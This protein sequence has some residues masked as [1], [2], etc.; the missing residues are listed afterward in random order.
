MSPLRETF[1]PSEQHEDS[2]K[3][4]HGGKT[5]VALFVYYLIIATCWCALPPWAP[6]LFLCRAIFQMVLITSLFSL[7]RIVVHFRVVGA[8]SMSIRICAGIGGITREV[9]LY[10]YQIRTSDEVA[11]IILITLT[12]M[13][14]WRV[15]P[16]MRSCHPP[17]PTRAS[18]KATRRTRDTRTRK[19]TQWM[20]TATSTAMRA[21]VG[22]AVPTPRCHPRWV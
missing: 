20:L 10:V 14:A 19:S 16:I 22:L 21:C 11:S 7:K 15:C 2:R 8:N 12:I 9:R 1:Q 6:F 3:H 4:P 18:A 17:R 5:Y 13:P